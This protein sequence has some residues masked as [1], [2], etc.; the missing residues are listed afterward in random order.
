[1]GGLSEGLRIGELSERCGVS[2]DT[3]R[4]YEREGLLPRPRRTASRYRVCDE[5]DEGRLRFIRR[6][7]ALGLTL[8]DIRAKPWATSPHL[9]KPRSTRSTT[10]RSG[11]CSL[12]KRSGYTRRNS[13][14]C[15]ST[16]R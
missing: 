2:P 9:M 4:F 10:G 14:M 15:C 11:P 7:Q 8:D 6:A 13:S 12:A 1:M 5:E 3:V 16:R